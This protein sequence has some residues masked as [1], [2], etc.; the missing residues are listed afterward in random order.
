MIIPK[1]LLKPTII[2]TISI[3]IIL[4]VAVL[5][6][7]L[8]GF[9]GGTPSYSFFC[10]IDLIGGPGSGFQGIHEIIIY[11]IIAFGLSAFLVKLRKM[12]KG[13]V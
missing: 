2:L 3:F 11:F 12:S 1:D 10:G 13:K 8:E 6:C 4:M 7:T 9:T 5:W